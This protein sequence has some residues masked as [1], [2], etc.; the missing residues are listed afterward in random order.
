[1]TSFTSLQLKTIHKQLEQVKSDLLSSS[2]RDDNGLYWQSPYY[3]D[4]VQV[5]FKTTVDIFNGNCGIALFYIGLFEFSGNREDLKMAEDIMNKVLQS[6]DVLKPRSFGF[7]T[8]LTGVAYV[9][10]KLYEL[11][12]EEKY[13]QRA[14]CLMLD[15]KENIVNNT[16]KADLLSGYCGSLLV[17]T[18]LYHH[19]KTKN[20]LAIVHQ[21][22]IE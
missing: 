13:L 18:L 10:I 2:R 4:A 19:L 17:M 20:L 6:D 1:M 12:K 15:N 3:E 5:S 8:G 7:Y 22:S 14:S 9:C 21:L 11:N 16:A